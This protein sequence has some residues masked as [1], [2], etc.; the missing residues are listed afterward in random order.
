MKVC[1]VYDSSSEDY[2]YDIKIVSDYYI[3]DFQELLEL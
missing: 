2:I 1:G 3:Y